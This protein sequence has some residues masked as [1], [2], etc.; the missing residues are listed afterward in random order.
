MPDPTGQREFDLIVIGAG[1]A[2]MT[3]ALVA[4]IQ[5]LEVVVIE[6]S[7]LVGG[8][9]AVSAGSIWIPNSHHA[10]PRSDSFVT[11]H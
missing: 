4:A 9:T 7:E 1:G 11:Q 2:G 6:K 5:G 8:T 10:T 3:A